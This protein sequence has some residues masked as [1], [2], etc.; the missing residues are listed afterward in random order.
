VPSTGNGELLEL[1]VLPSLRLRAMM[2]SVGG[3]VD[4][5]LIK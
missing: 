1:G 4:V 2:Q 5:E 3:C